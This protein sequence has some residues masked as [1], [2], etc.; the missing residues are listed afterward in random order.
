MQAGFDRSTPPVPP[1]PGA[2]P[3]RPRATMPPLSRRSTPVKA[4]RGA[5]CFGGGKGTDLPDPAMD[6][7]ATPRGPD[8]V[9]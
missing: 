2:S 8:D 1:Q 4:H 3:S 6:R 5:L 7:H 9:R